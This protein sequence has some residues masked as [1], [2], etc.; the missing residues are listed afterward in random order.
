MEAIISAM[1]DISQ[2]QKMEKFV[3]NISDLLVFAGLIPLK[4]IALGMLLP[5]CLKLF[6]DF[7]SSRVMFI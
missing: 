2:C 5:K 1:E 3:T 6:H 4:A 7:I